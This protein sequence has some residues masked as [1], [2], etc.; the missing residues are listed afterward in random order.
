MAL[1]SLRLELGLSQEAA[2]ERV[3]ITDRQL[4]R[5]ELGQANV[6][7]ATLV[8]CAVAYRVQLARLFGDDGSAR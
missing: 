2:A 1:R 8:A 4:R 3:G 6:T 5:L 7:L